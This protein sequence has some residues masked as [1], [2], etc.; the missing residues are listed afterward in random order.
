MSDEIQKSTIEV[1]I[2]IAETLIQCEKDLELVKRLAGITM[3][4]NLNLMGIVD[5]ELDRLDLAF[6]R[7]G[8]HGSCAAL[9]DARRA[10]LATYGEISD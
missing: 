8:L 1:Y 4:Q 2:E 10:I 6:Q 5:L 9:A 7:E 3:G